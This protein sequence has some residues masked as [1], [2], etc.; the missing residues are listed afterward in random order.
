MAASRRFNVKLRTVVEATIPVTSSEKKLAETK[1]KKMAANGQIKS[2]EFKNS[3]DID[4]VE[5]VDVTPL[6]KL[7]GKKPTPSKKV[8]AKK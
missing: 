4:V 1:A 7:K 3:R 5:I 8:P 2:W 6:P